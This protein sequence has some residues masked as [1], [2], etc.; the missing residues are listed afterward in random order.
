MSTFFQKNIISLFLGKISK[1]KLSLNYYKLHLI[2]YIMFA[3]CKN[4]APCFKMLAG[5]QGFICCIIIKASSAASSSRVQNHSSILQ[6]FKASSA[7]SVSSSSRVQNHSSILQGFKG[8]Q[9]QPLHPAFKPCKASR[10]TRASARLAGCT[11][12]AYFKPC[13]LAGLAARPAV[14]RRSRKHYKAF[15]QVFWNWIT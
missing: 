1:K 5:L 6:G 4:L 8:L 12:Q 15:G 3:P 2:I 9:V 11:L 7:A 10:I 14:W 13:T